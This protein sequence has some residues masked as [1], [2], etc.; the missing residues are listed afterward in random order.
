MIR[1]LLNGTP[2]PENYFSWQERK[3]TI[4]RSETL[5]GVIMTQNLD[6]QFIG[7]ACEYLIDLDEEF[8][9]AAECT[10]EIQYHD[11][12]DGWQTEWSGLLD[13]TTFKIDTQDLLKCTVSAYD[14]GFANKMLERMEIEVP[15]D[16]LTTLDGATI[17]PFANEYQTVNIDGIDI[18]A[19]NLV[20]LT[21]IY[22]NSEYISPPFSHS[23]TLENWVITTLYPGEPVGSIG[24][25]VAPDQDWINAR[26]FFVGAGSTGNIKGMFKLF[27][28]TGTGATCAVTLL[29]YKADSLT[30]VV[31]KTESGIVS[32]GYKEYEFELDYD[33]NE[34]ARFVVLMST[35]QFLELYDVDSNLEF[36][37]IKTPTPCKFVP[38]FEAGTRILEAITGEPLAIDSEYLGRTD[39]PVVYGSDGAG[40]DLFLTNGKLIR[41]F[42]VNWEGAK[43]SQLTFSLK[44]WFE[45][46]D[47]IKCLGAGV[48][49][50]KL[51]VDLRK[52]FY[53]YDIVA[54]FDRSQMEVDTF[55]IEKE[56]TKYFNEVEVGC[57]YEQPEEVSGLEEYNSKQ[58]YSTPIIN[59]N[60][61]ELLNTYIY[62]AYPFEFAR[63]KPYSDIET[64]DYK[65]DN[66]N[67]V[68]KVLR[69]ETGFKQH[70]D[71][72]F[73]TIDGLPNVEHFINLDITPKRNLLNWGWF[74]NSGFRAYQAKELVYNK[75]EI[76]TDLETQKVGESTPVK[77]CSN[78]LISNLENARFTGRLV[79]FSAA[80]PTSAFNAIKAN[81]YGLIQYY[82]VV[83]QDLGFGWLKEISTS[84]IDK[85]TNIELYEG[86]STIPPKGV[87]LLQ[88]GGVRLLEDGGERLL[89]NN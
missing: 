35:N 67:F 75:S 62:A 29:D 86:I 27:W 58:S 28:R 43:V 13:F 59:E 56:M 3:E 18:M 14:S 11:N 80:V 50:G 5:H 73:D 26:A 82:D 66:D 76:V 54:S 17:E 30:P 6:L 9:V 68:F 45:A 52:N 47:K 84:L 33:Y 24:G 20:K 36:T 21:P 16:R 64:I 15:Y 81:P 42:P 51:Y 23:T 2:Y 69:N 7:K 60:K 61:L 10:I 77:E 89:E 40:S 53:T 72:D 46:L 12:I 65:Y 63:R 31:I 41:Q 25:Y 70:S 38:P 48:R 1:A 79:R 44:S 22:P 19:T 4:S 74:I 37:S 8:D 85:K 83:K 32:N 55:E 88:D 57:E 39:S 34:T 87:R 71:E 49:D 78:V